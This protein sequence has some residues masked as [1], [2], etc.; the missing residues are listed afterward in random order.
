MY[1]QHAYQFFEEER[2]EMDFVGIASPVIEFTSHHWFIRW[3]LKK[4]P[5]L[6]WMLFGGSPMTVLRQPRYY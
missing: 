3:W 4:K 5:R 1:S 2:L 6:K